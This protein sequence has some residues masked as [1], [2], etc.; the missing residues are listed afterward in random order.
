MTRGNRSD[1]IDR[2]VTSHLDLEAEEQR[3]GG[4]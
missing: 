2:E 4:L 3:E 1:D